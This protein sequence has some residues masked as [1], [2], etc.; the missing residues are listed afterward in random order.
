MVLSL[1]LGAVGIGTAFAV[2]M[3]MYIAFRCL[4]SLSILGVYDGCAI[5][6]KS[7]R[8]SVLMPLAIY[9]HFGSNMFTKTVPI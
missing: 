3:E 1:F 7:N 6:C 8:S 9:T 4:A 2:N 5:L